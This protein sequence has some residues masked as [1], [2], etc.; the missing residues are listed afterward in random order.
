MEIDSADITVQNQVHG[1]FKIS[2]TAV[3]AMRTAGRDKGYLRRI[4]RVEEKPADLA[5]VGA[6]IKVEAVNLQKS[7]F[8]G[9]YLIAVTV[10]LFALVRKRKNK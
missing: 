4:T 7:P 5:D 9:M 2:K 10:G 3:Q 1:M 8:P 6:D